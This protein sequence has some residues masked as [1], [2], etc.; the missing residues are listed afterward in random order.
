MVNREISNNEL[1]LLI[2]YNTAF[3]SKYS[4]IKFLNI[5]EKNYIKRYNILPFNYSAERLNAE[6]SFISY[7]DK[8][9][10]FSDVYNHLQEAWPFVND[11]D[12]FKRYEKKLWLK[13]FERVQ[14]IK[15]AINMAKK[16][17]LKIFLYFD[18]Y[19]LDLYK[20]LNSNEK[21]RYF[22]VDSDYIRVNVS[23]ISKE[24]S[25]EMNLLEYC[26]TKDKFYKASFNDIVK[27]RKIDIK[28]KLDYILPFSAPKY[29]SNKQG[30]IYYRYGYD[31]FGPVILSYIEWLLRQHQDGLFK[32]IYF[33]SR[34]GY[35]F[36]KIYDALCENLGIE[37]HSH[38]L[39]ISKRATR[40]LS[41]KNEVSDDFLEDAFVYE[42]I[43]NKSISV[44]FSRLGL[45]VENYID[46]I[47]KFGFES[48]DS[49]I[50]MSKDKEKLWSLVKDSI[51]AKDLLDKAKHERKL[52]KAYLEQED[53]FKY[54][55]VAIMDLICRG[56]IHIRLANFVK[57]FSDMNIMSLNFATTIN[58]K[59]KCDS[60]YNLYG[61]FAT[62]GVPYQRI[63]I[64]TSMVG[65]LEAIFT[66]PHRSVK[67]YKEKDGKIIPEFKD[68]SIVYFDLTGPIQDGVFDYAIDNC[69]SLADLK[70]I[71]D[72]KCEHFNSFKRLYLHPN[73]QEAKY[74][75]ELEV[76][77]FTAI[78]KIASPLPLSKYFINRKE[79]LFHYKETP[80]KRA[81]FVNLLGE[82]VTNKKLEK[83]SEKM[84][85][86]IK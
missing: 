22:N 79:A 39:Y 1:R 71:Q 9:A 36:N 62:N 13:Y 81:Y 31:L 33:F 77:D 61:Y 34:D 73:K 38:Y 6:L 41:L 12:L 23:N 68:N 14:V 20:S 49:L 17:N 10:N 25:K 57:E 44:A 75:G 63:N 7:E 56:T 59:E 67:T 84:K 82:W 27:N 74:L 53:F 55:S 48:K 69:K 54:N 80:W 78:T 72:N 19:T 3:N 50:D 30:D 8:L 29:Y 47:N 64:L 24:I 76:D 40:L 2:T 52:A 5:I 16:S 18:D 65:L 21:E 15:K 85:G 28:E 37:K 42:C 4:E 83:Y 26:A 45:P 11:L 32:T 51:I 46:L 43:D 58:A 35:L 60:G 70:N 66:A 86:L